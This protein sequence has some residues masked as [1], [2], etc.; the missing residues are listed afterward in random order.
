MQHTTFDSLTRQL[1]S[2]LSRRHLLRRGGAAGALALLLGSRLGTPAR[3]TDNRP[4][5]VNMANAYIDVCV[6]SG[7]EPDVEVVEG[8]VEVLC[9]NEE[10]ERADYCSFSFDGTVDCGP[11]PSLLRQPSQ[12]GDLVDGVVTSV[13]D[14][15]AGGEVSNDGSGATPG[16]PV[17]AA[18]HRKR[19]KGH[20]RHR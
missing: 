3:A 1:G 20:K 6:A 4:Q 18:T 14:G 16:A 12:L 11:V 8:G 7:G 9:F 13:V 15:H 17:P 5:A 19:R 10:Q 2:P